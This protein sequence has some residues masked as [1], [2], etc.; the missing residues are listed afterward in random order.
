MN[1][2]P[3]TEEKFNTLSYENRVLFTAFYIFLFFINF[4]FLI[5]GAVYFAGNTWILWQAVSI[6]VQGLFA[7]LST[8]VAK[9]INSEGDV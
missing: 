3:K 8:M 1:L 2:F 7:F 4:S 9:S 5:I 6:P